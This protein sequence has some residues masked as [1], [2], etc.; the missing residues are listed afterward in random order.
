M[1]RRSSRSSTTAV[2]SFLTIVSSPPDEIRDDLQ[3]LDDAFL[4]YVDAVAGLDPG[5]LDREALEKLQ[6]P[7]PWNEIDQ[8]K[9][10]QAAQNIAAWARENC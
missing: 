4:K 9:I 3:V 2:F 6:K 1:P 7:K 8:Q 10:R 5:N